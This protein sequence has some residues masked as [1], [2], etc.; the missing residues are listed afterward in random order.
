[1]KLKATEIEMFDHEN[2]VLHFES[3][4]SNKEIGKEFKTFLKSEYNQRNSHL[5]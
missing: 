2:F 3:A 4:F 5:S 1:M